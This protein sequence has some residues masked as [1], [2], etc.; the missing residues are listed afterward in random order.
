VLSRKNRPQK[1]VAPRGPVKEQAA[2][3]S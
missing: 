2:P 3:T 1:P